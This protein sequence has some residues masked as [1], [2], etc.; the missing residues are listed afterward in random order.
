[1]ASTFGFYF[2]GFYLQSHIKMNP[3]FARLQN[4]DNQVLP[5]ARNPA[6]GPNFTH[7]WRVSH[8]SCHG[9]TPLRCPPR[10]P[11][12]RHSICRQTARRTARVSS[13]VIWLC[14]WLAASG[15][16]PKTPQNCDMVGQG[17]DRPQSQ[18]PHTGDVLSGARQTK[19]TRHR[20]RESTRHRAGRTW[21]RRRASCS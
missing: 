4:Q 1:M 8:S 11:P 19:R 18:G 2:N 16:L 14:T 15:E 6:Q 3:T 7:S 12:I 10:D 9:A 20:E 17:G 5:R 21:C 13:L